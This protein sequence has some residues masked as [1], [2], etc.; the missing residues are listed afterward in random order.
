[1]VVEL[2]SKKGVSNLRNLQV[3]ENIKYSYYIFKLKNLENK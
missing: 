3:E 1:M 2:R